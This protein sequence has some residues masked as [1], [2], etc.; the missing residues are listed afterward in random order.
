MLVSY[1]Y[2]R[3]IAPR[4]SIAI[5]LPRCLHIG[6][7]ARTYKHPRNQNINHSHTASRPRSRHVVAPICQISPVRNRGARTQAILS[8]KD[9]PMATS[10]SSNDPGTRVPDPDE[11]TRTPTASKDL[12]DLFESPTPLEPLVLVNETPSYPTVILQAR[13]NMRKFDNCVLLT[14]VGAFYEMY[15]EHALQYGPQLNLKVVDKKTVAGPVPMVRV[16][17]ARDGIR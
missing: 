8:L 15:F 9:L 5:H 7:H 6:A 16:L 11:R 14:R 4:S 2:V 1:Q 3:V 10:Q 13:N 12:H 17:C